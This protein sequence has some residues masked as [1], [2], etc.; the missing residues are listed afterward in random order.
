MAAAGCAPRVR[1]NSRPWAKT[2]RA[3]IELTWK[4]W[5][6]EGSRSV[7]T[8]ATRSLPAFPDAT[9]SSSGATILQGPH[10]DAQKSTRTGTDAPATNASNSVSESTSMGL[11]IGGRLDLHAPQ[12]VEVA[13]ASYG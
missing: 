7:L 3:G 9:R 13:S 11:S 2:A 5:A 8:F 4:R 10:Q 6:S 12:R 1:F